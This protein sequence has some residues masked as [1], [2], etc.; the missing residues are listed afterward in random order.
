MEACTVLVHA[1]RKK[2]LLIKDNAGYTPFQ[3]ATDK[4]HRQIAHILVCY[5][6]NN[7]PPAFDNE[8]FIV[9]FRSCSS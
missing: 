8:V 3:L 7:V 2:E 6:N 9:L 4:G 1:G 5:Q